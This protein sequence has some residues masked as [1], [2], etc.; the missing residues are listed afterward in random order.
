MP[1]HLKLQLAGEIGFLSPGLGV[2]LASG[3][4]HLD[5]FL[6]WVPEAVGGKDILSV[7]G[8]LSYSP[9]RVKVAPRWHVVPLTAGVQMTYTFGSQYFV[10][11]PEHYPSGYY[12]MPTAIDLGVSF[13]GALLKQ[14]R[15]SDRQ[16]GVYYEVVALAKMLMLWRENP[17]FLGP[18]DVLST[19]FGAVVQ[20]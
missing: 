1:D 14:Q 18:S 2:D 5:L 19:S 20:F 13:G 15:G 17:E 8:K 16:L 4:A 3:R 6:G 11:A 9:W 12:E 10:E 7:T